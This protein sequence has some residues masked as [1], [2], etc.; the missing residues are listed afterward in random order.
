MSIGDV[1]QEHRRFITIV[2]A[3][4]LILLIGHIVIGSIYTGK[5]R[6]LASDISRARA[7]QSQAQ[8]PAGTDLRRI[9]ADRERLE[10]EASELVQAVGHRPTERW[11]VGPG[12]A[13]P[14]LHYNQQVEALRN[15]V[16]ELA[17]IR[18]IDVDPKLGLPDAFPGSRA[19][20]EHYLRGLDVVESVISAALAAEQLHEAGIARIEG[21]EISK[22]PKP[23]QS[24]ERKVPFVTS[25]KIDLTVV[26]HPKA[27]DWMLKTLAAEAKAERLGRYVSIQEAAIKSLDLAPGATAKQKRGADPADRRR[28]ECRLGIL[29]LT[30]NPEGTIL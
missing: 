20:I 13:D 29:A 23:R 4:G 12:I 17:A 15:G 26:G 2:G 14:D 9:I 25:L 27:I 6:R 19:E 30:V 8:L 7:A 22:P 10:R 24:G 28:V 11:Q 18:N 3:G 16:V 5:A 1:W 21:I